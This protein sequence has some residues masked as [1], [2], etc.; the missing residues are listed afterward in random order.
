MNDGHTDPMTSGGGQ[1]VNLGTLGSIAPVAPMQLTPNNG[2]IIL[3]NGAPKKKVNKWII[4]AIVA[5]VLSLG[6]AIVSIIVSNS[7]SNSGSYPLKTAF[8]EYANYLLYGE[9]SDEDITDEYVWGYRY[10]ANSIEAQLDDD[11]Y[12]EYLDKLKVKYDDFVAYFPSALEDYDD[13]FQIFYYE[14]TDPNLTKMEV[15]QLVYGED[16]TDVLYPQV[17][18]DLYSQIWEMMEEIYV[19]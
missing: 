17:Y 7:G 4:V 6:L 14:A 3:N 19:E 15:L 1:N 2:S 12:A 11:A 10:Y 18:I 5:V 9:D 13:I 16:L 8:N